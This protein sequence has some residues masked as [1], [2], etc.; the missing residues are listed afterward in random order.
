MT[1]TVSLELPA[2]LAEL[3]VT[4]FR[5][6]VQPLVF[7]ADDRREIRS[8]LAGVD[9]SPKFKDVEAVEKLLEAE[10]RA[11]TP[12]G[13]RHLALQTLW[14]SAMTGRARREDADKALFHSRRAA[15]GFAL[16]G[17]GEPLEW[18]VF[19]GIW[20]EAQWR[21]QRMDLMGGAGL[22]AQ[23]KQ[24]L[25][26]GSLAGA[27]QREQGALLEIEMLIV[28]SRLAMAAGDPT[29]GEQMVL[30]AAQSTDDL[31]ATYLEGDPDR[32]Y[33][34][35]RAGLLRAWAAMFSANI[36]I[37]TYNFDRLPQGQADAAAQARDLLKDV[38][39]MEY[40]LASF[41]TEMLALYE[42]LSATMAR[43]LGSTLQA[44]KSAFASLH[45][46][47]QSARDLIPPGPEAPG[48][49]RQ[50]NFMEASLDNVARLSRPT[51]KDLGVY[52]G[53]VTCIA[54]CV[55]LLVVALINK[56][57]SV[58]ANA[59]EIIGACTPLA[60]LAG[61]GLTGLKAWRTGAAGGDA[62][63]NGKATAA[64]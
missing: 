27:A 25:E 42:D 52:G 51:P 39:P 7:T 1:E 15:Y 55:L 49:A 19:V 41:V 3:P 24:V 2:E 38:G 16:L 4:E 56:T 20:C 31:A 54:F 59:T 12:S 58:G 57:L 45:Q 46:R 33:L 26:T 43:L 30:T 14:E 61:F 6:R 17:E 62:A 35:G 11:M 50:L 37:S 5:R 53:V 36:A 48:L 34:R 64:A 44:D 63:G 23:A 22:F 29:G 8:A 32:T 21:L 10:H 60:V 18:A 40:R 13:A 28:Q 9:L 47:V